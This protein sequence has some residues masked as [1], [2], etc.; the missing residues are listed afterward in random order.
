MPGLFSFSSETTLYNMFK[1]TDHIEAN[2]SLIPD[3]T[4]W[5]HEDS[6]KIRLSVPSLSLNQ[7]ENTAVLL[8]QRAN[9]CVSSLNVIL[10]H[11]FVQG[12]LL[13]AVQSYTKQSLLPCVGHNTG[14]SDPPWSRVREYF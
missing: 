11:C 13:T 9:E 6:K 1:F 12:F 5:C 10:L 2:S 3:R 4:G 7:Y 14:D 8:R